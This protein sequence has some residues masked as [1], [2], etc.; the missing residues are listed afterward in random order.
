M[1]I[2]YWLA[3]IA[4]VSCRPNLDKA[5]I[6]NNGLRAEGKISAD[7][8]FDGAIK[9]Y[10]VN[11]NKLVEETEYDR[12]VRNG[13]DIV[14]FPQGT[15]AVRSFYKDG[16]EN[17]SSYIY[18]EK[19]QLTTEYFFYYG[20]RMGNNV[21]YSNGAASKYWFYSLDDSVLFYF[22]YDSIKGKRVPDLQPH[23]FFYH[24]QQFNTID[25]PDSLS[26]NSEYFIY[27]PNPPRLDFK[28]DLVLVDSSRNVL[29]ILKEF[30]KTQPWSVFDLSN[31]VESSNKKTALRL[32]IFDSINNSKMWSLKL[33]N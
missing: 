22:D 17:G 14:Y 29:S 6:M 8:V 15:V 27:T 30:S 23:F 26:R 20:I 4:L 12:G 28:Y 2:I 1:K 24:V 21:R 33:L 32:Q 11:T 25:K 10:D 16:K 9:F 5:M 7:S 3:I 13:H 18:N 19:E 31:K